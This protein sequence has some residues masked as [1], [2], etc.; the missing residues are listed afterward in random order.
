[1]ALSSTLKL[2][3]K[4]GAL[5]AAANWPLTI[6]QAVAD[7]LFKLLVAAPLF[8]GI[9]LV[10]LVVGAEPVALLSLEWRDLA[11][12]IAASL[13]A[14]PIVLMAWVASLGVVIAGGSSSRAAPSASWFAASGM[15]G[16][17]NNRRCFPT[18]SHR[19]PHSRWIRSSK[20]PTRCLRPTRG[21]DS[22]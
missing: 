21:W 22:C 9:F 11:A 1:V 13:L 18:W 2:T 6:I 20:V 15:R 19:P 4:R 17:S 16:R 10:A 5:V 8:G 14:K 7:S 12:T 3:L